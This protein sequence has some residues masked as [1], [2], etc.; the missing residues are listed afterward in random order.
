MWR[1][2][3]VDILTETNGVDFYNILYKVPPVTYIGDV[4]ENGNIFALPN[5]G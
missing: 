1:A 2:M 5:G 4:S 3:E